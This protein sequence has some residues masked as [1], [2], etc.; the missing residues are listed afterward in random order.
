MAGVVPDCRERANNATEVL[1]DA[2]IVLTWSAPF[3]GREKK[4]L[5]F[6]AQADEYWGKRAAEGRCTQ[7]E[8]FFLPTGGGMWMVKGER[9]VL[10]EL[11]Q[12]DEA[13][14]L[15]VKGSCWSRIGATRLLITEAGLRVS[16]VN[17]QER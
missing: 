8:W 1:M 7:P 14:R 5:E 17:T 12:T 6:V 10:E 2:A 13:R 11:I 3:P 9:R 16:W 4:T 15:L